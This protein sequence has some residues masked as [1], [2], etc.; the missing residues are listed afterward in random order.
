MIEYAFS[1]IGDANVNGEF[2]S[3]D[4]VQVFVAGKYEKA[5]AA[6][7]SQGDWNGDGFFNSGDMVAAFVDGGYEKGQ[8]ASVAAV[9]EP[10]G[11]LCL[12]LGVVL[13]SLRC[14]RR[15]TA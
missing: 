1:W 13:V 12:L 11:V 9:P 6:V 5:E 8:R 10:G 4:M 14:R 15:V 2:N 7:W 3:G